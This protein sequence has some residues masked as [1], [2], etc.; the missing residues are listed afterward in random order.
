MS[1]NH[2]VSIPLGDMS[3]YQPTPSP[4]PEPAVAGPSSAPHRHLPKQAFSSVEYPGPVSHPSALL[5]VVSQEDINECF[6]ATYSPAAPPVLEMRYRMEDYAA[7]PV[8]GL[9][10]PSQ[11]LLL[12]ITRRRKRAREGGDDKGKEKDSDEGVFTSEVVGPVTNTVRFRSESDRLQSDR[13]Q[14]RA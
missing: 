13:L 2:P 12:K 10:A 7:V 3:E 8:R 9:R 5:K 11:K 4:S 1:N 14:S 6:N